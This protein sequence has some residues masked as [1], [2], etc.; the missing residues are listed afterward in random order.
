MSDNI[1]YD[2]LDRAIAESQKNSAAKAAAAKSASRTSSKT[3]A[4]PKAAA[5]KAPAKATP[6][7][8]NRAP[9]T[10]VISTPAQDLNKNFPPRRRVYMDFIGR[11]RNNIQNNAVRLKAPAE[12]EA[13][14]KVAHFAAATPDMPNYRVANSRQPIHAQS[15]PAKPLMRKATPAPSVQAKPVSRQ[16]ELPKAPVRRVI[17]SAPAITKTVAKPV[18]AAPKPVQKPAPTPEMQQTAAAAAE[19]AQAL[20]AGPRTPN[21]NNYSIG[22]R[23]PYIRNDAKV[24]K[25]PL[26]GDASE[27]V[28]DDKIEKNEYPE[29]PEKTKKKKTRSKHTVKKDKQKNT[30]WYWPILVVLIVAAG[31]GLGYLLWW[32]LQGAN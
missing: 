22:V 15:I 13:P 17:P 7:K 30:S 16:P 9:A 31:G 19:A 14:R 11:P 28:Q 4:K 27:Y 6:V 29:Q 1:D 3:T 25:R 21:A 10:P 23:S 18:Q 5:T 2:E 8:I 12:D 24:S 26:N 20:E 32:I